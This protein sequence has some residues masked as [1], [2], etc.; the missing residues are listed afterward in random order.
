[1]ALIGFN[2]TKINVE[3]KKPATGKI[4]ISTGISFTKLKEAKI[5]FL[6]KKSALD[7]EFKFTCK[8]D[9]EI[10][11]IELKGT[12]IE[13]FEE[14]LIKKSIEEW[15]KNK[16]LLPKI[17]QVVMNDIMNKCYVEALLLSNSLSMPAP[18]PLPKIKVQTK[19]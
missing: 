12:A 7:I 19:Q 9:P 10:G 6:N 8:Y 18:I 17:A 14:E 11:I 4:N 15:K 3:K 5:N 16:K 13:F 1:M 2:F